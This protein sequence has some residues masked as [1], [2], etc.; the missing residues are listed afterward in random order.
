M[1][2]E[3]PGHY[4]NSCV[5]SQHSKSEVLSDKLLKPEIL[6]LIKRSVTPR[7]SPDVPEAVDPQLV[8]GEAPV[9][10]VIGRPDQGNIPFEDPP[11]LVLSG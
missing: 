4:Y 10:P 11:P 7:V 8:A 3:N 2:M 6:F 1:E 5:A 9:I